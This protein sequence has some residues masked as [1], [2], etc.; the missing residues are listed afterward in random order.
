MSENKYNVLA[1][2]GW[3]FDDSVWQHLQDK[4]QP[5]LQMNC[6][7]RGYFSNAL[8]PAWPN[9]EGTENLLLVHSYGLHWCGKEILENTDHLVMISS[10]LN[11]HP[12]KK[13]EYKRSK[14]MLRKM[15]AQFVDAP[16]K[17]LE[18]YYER[19]FYPLEPQYRA[20]TTLNH[21]LLLSDLSDLDKDNRKNAHVF[22]MNSITIIHGA[23][24]QIVNNELARDMYKKLR[25]RSQYFEI[26]KGGHALPFTHSSKIIEILN[27]LF[28]FKKLSDS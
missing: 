15:L 20:P 18:N 8:Q 16:H 24:D 13:K 11:F 6:A 28:N 25:L 1:Y 7:R 9:E 21:D 27:S 10:F 19:A 4:Y 26:K 22:D 3:G 2:H 14:L 17:V 12:G 23:D 5:L